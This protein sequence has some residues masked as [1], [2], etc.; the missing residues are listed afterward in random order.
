MVR[1]IL[2]R[3]I[4]HHDIE[5]CANRI[6]V[7]YYQAVKLYSPVT[8]AVALLPETV[9]MS[10]ASGTVGFLANKWQGYRWALW[11]GWTLTTIGAGLLS[12]LDTDTTTTQ[13]IFLNIPF[14]IGT[15]MLFTPQ[16]LAIQAATE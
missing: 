16:L 2:S 14:G 7:L 1:N 6:T 13:W 15:G 9:G 5:F 3:L 12:K 4:T 11:S 8:S 10:I